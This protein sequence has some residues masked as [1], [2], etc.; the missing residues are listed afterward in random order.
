MPGDFRCTRCYSCAFYHYHCTR[1][2]G[3]IGHP[4]FPTPSL[5]G[6]RFFNGSGAWRGEIVKVCLMHA[7]A[8]HSQPSS[9]ANAGDPVLRGVSDGI[10]KPRR[11]G[12]PHA[13]GMTVCCGAATRPS[14][15]EER[16]RT[17][18]VVVEARRVAR[19][20]IRSTHLT[21]FWHCG[22]RHFSFRTA[23]ERLS[24]NEPSMV[25]AEDARPKGS[26]KC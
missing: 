22:D 11:T 17:R 7:S 26:G 3:C 8:P 4:A 14:E 13:R 6:E 24:R 20:S 25:L 16:R 1:D 15:L 5:G 18:P 10:E 19:P 9:P 2:R 12:Y 21:I 23:R